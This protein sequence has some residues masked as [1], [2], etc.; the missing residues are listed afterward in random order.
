MVVNPRRQGF[1]AGPRLGLALSGGGARGL[2]HI[3]VLKVLTREGIAISCLAGT[4][5]GGLLAAAYA[6]GNSVERL[7]QEA[8][9]MADLR[10]LIQ[11]V[12]W[13]PPRG[14]LLDAERVRRFLQERLS[15]DRSFAELKHPLALMAV[16]LRS[17]ELVAMKEASLLNAVRATTALPGLFPPVQSADGPLVDG[18]LLN[19]LPVDQ[20]PSLGA[21]VTIGVDVGF[22]VGKEVPGEGI[23][24]LSSMPE[25]A[26]ELYQAAMLVLSEMTAAR[27]RSNPPDLL[28]RPQVPRGIGIL[29]GFPEAEAIIAA[30]ERAA[31]EAIPKL[32]GLTHWSPGRLVKRL[33]PR[34]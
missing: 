28:I 18:G 7:E 26:R 13:F 32:R 29:V 21:H 17:S 31:E 11:L 4:S 23:P 27:L 8:L 12:E 14:F 5:M 2:A 1:G 24:L 30:G 25:A 22:Q 19:N 9:R 10:Q 20:L 3:G 34:T 15:L 16:N 6:A 33:L